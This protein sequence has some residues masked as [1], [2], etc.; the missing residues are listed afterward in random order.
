MVVYQRFS[1]V[2]FALRARPEL[3]RLRGGVVL[4]SP[5]TI[6]LTRVRVLCGAGAGIWIM[7]LPMLLGRYLDMRGLTPQGILFGWLFL[8]SGAAFF[9]YAGYEVWRQRRQ[10]ERRARGL[11]LTCGYDLRGISSTL[12][13][14]CGSA[15]SRSGI[16]VS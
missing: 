6:W 4:S 10:E 15:Q 12:C 13:P 1:F 7:A 11:C 9:A 16:P 5:P 14:E 2:L 8:A 3:R